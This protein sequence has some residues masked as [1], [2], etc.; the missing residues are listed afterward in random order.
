M[1]RKLYGYD[2][3]LEN[4]KEYLKNYGKNIEDLINGLFDSLTKDK[5]YRLYKKYIM[6]ELDYIWR[7]RPPTNLWH[8]KLTKYE[9]AS[10]I[11]V[12]EMARDRLKKHL[13]EVYL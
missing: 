5:R 9:L 2:T 12:F 11:A 7:D 8:T 6:D 10:N 13:K 4:N 3:L 1:V